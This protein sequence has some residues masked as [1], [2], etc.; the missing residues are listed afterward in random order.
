MFAD[1]NFSFGGA[2]I[3]TS[4]VVDVRK[5]RTNNLFVLLFLY[6]GKI[7]MNCFVDKSVEIELYAMG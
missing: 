7:A 4:T 6:L 2:T 5:L 1:N 3:L